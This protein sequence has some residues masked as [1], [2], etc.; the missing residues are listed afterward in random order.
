MKKIQGVLTEV[1][2]NDIN[3]LKERP[4]EFWKDVE[5]IGEFAFCNSGIDNVAVPASVKKLAPRAF[6]SCKYLT[7]VALP[8]S[9]NNVS[10]F[11]FQWCWS[12]KKVLLPETITKIEKGAFFGCEALEN[13]FLPEGIIK[14]EDG[15]FEHCHHLCKITLPKS[16]EKVGA[17]VFNQCAR[18]KEI[19]A[20]NGE[21][22]FDEK[23]FIG[24]N[25]ETKLF[26]AQTE[27]KEL[28][29]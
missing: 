29:D 27:E 24:L 1:N 20:L 8:E 4:D 23:A 5:E 18:L 7:A 26:L 13:I 10:K 28:E 16:L 22:D 19:Y 6:D 11:A 25:K 9:M 17:K 21:T 3:L 12:L 15:A 14:I 2:K